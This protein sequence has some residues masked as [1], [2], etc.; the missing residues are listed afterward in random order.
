MAHIR[1]SLHIDRSPAEVFDF[2]S[3][4]RNEPASIPT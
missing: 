3:D 2:L 4:E 1:G